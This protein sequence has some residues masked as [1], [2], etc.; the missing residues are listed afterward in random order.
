MPWYINISVTVLG[1]TAD[2]SREI[3]ELLASQSN[4]SQKYQLSRMHTWKSNK[5]G[6]INQ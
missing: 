3:I 6:M 5:I 2:I 1:S 4:I